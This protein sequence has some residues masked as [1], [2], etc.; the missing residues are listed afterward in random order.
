VGLL[1]IL[2]ELHIP[3]A[4]LRGMTTVHMIHGYIGAG[5]TTFARELEQRL[6]T[7]RLTHDE[8]MLRLYGGDPPTEQFQAFSDKVSEQIEFVWTGCVGLGLDVVLDL[9][10]WSRKQRDSVRNIAATL[11][12]DVRLYHLSC[13]DEIAWGRVNNRNKSLTDSLF[14]ARNTF[15]MLKDRFEPLNDDEARIE[16][17]R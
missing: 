16:V 2:S 14:I 5:K 4:N 12:A 11:R 9:N 8:W 13:P 7:L 1:P 15:L 17:S 3:H 6:P 10:F